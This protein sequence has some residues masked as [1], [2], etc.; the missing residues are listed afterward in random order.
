MLMQTNQSVNHQ[1]DELMLLSYMTVIHGQQVS[2]PPPTP[3]MQ[4]LPANTQAQ[5]ARDAPHNPHTTQFDN[6]ADRTV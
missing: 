5:Q 6:T 2:S 4:A 3:I 1:S